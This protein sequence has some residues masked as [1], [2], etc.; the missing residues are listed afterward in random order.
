VYHLC[1]HVKKIII[2]KNP[3][4]GKLIKNHDKIEDTFMDMMQKI[5]EFLEL[6]WMRN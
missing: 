5:S 2:I 1:I 3:A 6:K 4:N